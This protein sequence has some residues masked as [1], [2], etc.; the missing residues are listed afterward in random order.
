MA[1]FELKGQSTQPSEFRLGV[2]GTTKLNVIKSLPAAILREVRFADA[3]GSAGPNVLS[4][5]AHC[6]LHAEIGLLS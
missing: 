4:S 1:C 5:A 2:S 6:I 3:S